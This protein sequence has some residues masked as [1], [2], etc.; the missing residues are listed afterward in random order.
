MTVPNEALYSDRNVDFIEEELNQ[1]ENIETVTDDVELLVGG[2]VTTDGE[3]IDTAS[4]TLT[5]S[6]YDLGLKTKNFMNITTD[7]YDVIYESM[8]DSVGIILMNMQNVKSSDSTTFSEKIPL[9]AHTAQSTLKDPQIQISFDYPITDTILPLERTAF[10]P[11][12]REAYDNGNAEYISLRN[13]F[14]YQPLTDGPFQPYAETIERL[15]LITDELINDISSGLVTKIDITKTT[16]KLNFTDELFQE[17]IEDE[18]Q[19]QQISTQSV[20]TSA[21][22]TSA[23]RTVTVAPTVGGGGSGPYGWY[24]RYKTLY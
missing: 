18:T 13:K 6:K 11:Y 20:N 8:S 9:L 17:I 2:S 22:D 4:F 21:T 15:V 19:S 10:E 12:G 24:E 7:E 3:V 23:T 5:E 14:G 16:A 1:D